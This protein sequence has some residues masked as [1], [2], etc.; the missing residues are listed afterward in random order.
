MTNEEQTISNLRK[1]KSFHNGSYGADIDRAIKA[2][3]QIRWIPVSERLPEIHQD[4]LL[5]LRSLDVVVG[6]RAE[7]ESY[8]YSQGDYIEP[9]NVLAWMPLPKPYDPQE[10]EDKEWINEL[11]ERE[12]RNTSLN[13]VSLADYIKENYTA[14]KLGKWLERRNIEQLNLET[15]VNLRWK[16]ECSEC[17]YEVRSKY[18]YC[19]NLLYNRIQACEKDNRAL[20][21][22]KK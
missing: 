3:E 15:A 9:Q 8:F 20:S 22:G 12:L 6:F 14:K 18:H 11:F 5:S 17:G 10:N 19:P 7:T 2:L 21:Q 4:V 16:Y 13:D 1:I